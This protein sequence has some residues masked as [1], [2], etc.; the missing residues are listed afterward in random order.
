[1]NHRISYFLLALVWLTTA[2]NEEDENPYSDAPANAEL[3]VAQDE[4]FGSILTNSQGRTL[5]FFANDIKGEATCEGDCKA[6][7]P[8]FF[9][10]NLKA[11]NGLN[12]Q[13]LVVITRADGEKQATYKGWPLYYFVNDAVAGEVLVTYGM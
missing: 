3:K 5:Y 10:E 9:Q 13:D 8:V 1:M 4:N 12:Q 7:W 2:C 6:A 11:G